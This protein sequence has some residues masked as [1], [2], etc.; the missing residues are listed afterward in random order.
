[1][2]CRYLVGVLEIF[3]ECPGDICWVSWK[4][5]VNVL[6]IFVRVLEIFDRYSVGFYG[7]PGDF[8]CWYW[9]Y[10]KSFLE[11]FDMCPGEI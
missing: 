4:Y 8:L 10:L 11:I 9:R 3:V 1:V 6:E 7:C 5:L 2:C